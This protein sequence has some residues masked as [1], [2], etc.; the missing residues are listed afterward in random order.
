MKVEIVSLMQ[1]PGAWHKIAALGKLRGS[2]IEIDDA[3]GLQILSECSEKIKWE[4][5]FV[6]S[7][8]DPMPFEDWPWHIKKIAALR[9]KKDAGVGDTLERM[10]GT[11]GGE[12]SKTAYRLLTGSDCGCQGRKEDLNARYIYS[13]D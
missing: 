7:K 4:P 13:V 5:D 10:F 11:I 12:Q 8:I 9:N 2:A 3:A 1:C 6:E